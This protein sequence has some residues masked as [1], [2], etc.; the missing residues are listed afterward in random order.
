MSD[1]NSLSSLNQ[2]Y[3]RKPVLLGFMGNRGFFPTEFTVDGAKATQ[4]SVNTI[5]GDGVDYV[6]LGNIETYADAKRAAFIVKR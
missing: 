4:T 1:I 3:R 2:K 5:L 6:D